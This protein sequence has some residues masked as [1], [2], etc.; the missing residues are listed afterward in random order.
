[1]ETAKAIYIDAVAAVSG[2]TGEVHFDN[3]NSALD[4]DGNETSDVA[5]YIVWKSGTA[6]VI[7]GAYTQT[8][9]KRAFILDLSES[10]GYQ[11]LVDNVQVLHNGQPTVLLQQ[12]VTK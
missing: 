8:I 9:E 7:T 4:A 6:A 3:V 1:M 11:L 12:L 2:A 10:A 5:D